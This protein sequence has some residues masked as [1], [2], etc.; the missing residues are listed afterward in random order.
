ML[1]EV[2]DYMRLH[3][4][5]IHTERTY[6]DW[7]KRF[8]QFHD[9]KS[10]ND[11]SAG[12]KKIELFLIHLA[13]QGNVS[14]TTQNQAMNA[15][16]F[17]YKK[18][19]NLPLDDEINAVRAHKKVNVPVVM[20]REE[21]AKVIALTNGTSQLVVKLMYGSGLRIPVCV[22]AQAGRKRSGCGY[23]RLIMN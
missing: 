19:L 22:S 17:L 13:V 23:K 16:V 9:M 4:Y 3:H 11:L 15:L 2:R 20:T 21:T 5:S 6:C 1:D 7:I 8:V 10:R 12:E 18:V 14:P